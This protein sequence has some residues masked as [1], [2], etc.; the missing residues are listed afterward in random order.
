MPLPKRVIEPIFVARSVYER[1]EL[2]GDLETVTNT[3]L[4]NIMRQLSSLARHSEDLFG[5]LARETNNMADRANSLQGRIDRLSIKVTQL[6]SEAKDVSLKDIHKKKAFKSATQFDQDIFS[7]A[8]MPTAMLETYQTCDKP[9]PLD[10]LNCYRDDGKDGLKF[11]TDPNYFFDL[12]R[13]D[14]LQE[15]E[16]MKNDRYKQ[17]HKPKSESN[18]SSGGG[19]RGQ[20][21]RPRQP[22]NT[23]EK[24]RQIAIGHGETLMPNNVI[25]RTPNSI[26]NQQEVPVYSTTDYYDGRPNR[27]NSIELRRSYPEGSES[28]YAPASP[29]YQQQMSYP[30]QMNDESAYNSAMYAQSQ[31]ESPYG[32]PGTPSRGGKIRPTQPPPAPPSSGSG[33]TPNVSNANTPTRGRSMSQG[34]DVLPPPPPIPS[35]ISSPQQVANGILRHPGR[36]SMN[37]RGDSPQRTDLNN[38]VMA[39][40]NSQITNIDINDLPPPPPVPQ[41]H[42]SPS[43]NIAPPAPPIA[44]PPPALPNGNL[45]NGITTNN[46]PANIITPPPNH[47]GLLKEIETGIS[48]RKVDPQQQNQ[49]SYNQGDLMKEIREGIK[50]RKVEQMRDDIRQQKQSNLH[51][52]ASILARRVAIELS[53]SES[54]SDD[55]DEE[56]MEPNETSA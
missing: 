45:S 22:T 8:T 46:K 12:W 25:Y 56:W 49:R 37:T 28:G 47:A 44:P 54:D 24:Q 26:V 5:E 40:L 33:G 42:M 31:I 15:T 29:H 4:T 14:I 21:K 36:T 52:V 11:Y 38:H 39:Q 27:P 43:N 20:N 7:R 41:Y 6:D 32:A 2:P 23:R 1:N 53:D 18:A 30:Q 48:L 16:R 51:D 50:L 35:N 34:R 17:K 13:Q 55:S 10:K 3:T 19:K 9:P